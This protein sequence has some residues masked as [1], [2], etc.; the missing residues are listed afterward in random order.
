MLLWLI[1]CLVWL[2]CTLPYAAPS[3]FTEHLTVTPLLNGNMLL[4]FKFS[5]DNLL[6]RRCMY[7]NSSSSRSC[8][9]Q[10]NGAPRD[11]AQ[12]YTQLPAKVGEVYFSSSRGSWRPHEWGAPACHTQGT[13]RACQPRPVP[14]AGLFARVTQRFPPLDAASLP[15]TWALLTNAA[16]AAQSSHRGATK[17]YPLDECRPGPEACTWAVHSAIKLPCIDELTCLTRLVPS[18][19]ELGAALNLHWLV[20]APYYS[21]NV[22][23]NKNMHLKKSAGDLCV[24]HVDPDG[25]SYEDCETSTRTEVIFSFVLTSLVDEPT[26]VRQQVTDV[27]LTRENYS[28][29]IL[30]WLEA[31]WASGYDGDQ[32]TTESEVSSGPWAALR[33]E[34]RGE[35]DTSRPT[36]RRTVEKSPL[37][38]PGSNCGGAGQGTCAGYTLTYSEAP[39]QGQVDMRSE[40]LPPAIDISK[41]VIDSKAIDVYSEVTVRNTH[42]SQSAVLRVV[43]P[44]QLDDD[45]SNA[46]LAVL[47]S[48]S[49]WF[50]PIDNSSIREADVLMENSSACV[51][52]HG[53][54]MDLPSAYLLPA[55]A[56]APP[57][58]TAG[59]PSAVTFLLTL[60]PKC[61]LVLSLEFRKRFLKREFI[62]TDASKGIHVP[63]GAVHW[64]WDG[65]EGVWSTYIAP[66]A[67]VSVPFPDASMPFN[68]I[69]MVSTAFALL[70]GSMMNVL[71]R[72]SS[73]KQP[74]Q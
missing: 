66:A 14:P 25:T 58:G 54:V 5:M 12:L 38:S 57:A 8:V 17:F 70:L 6:K 40:A 44:L 20:N 64:R 69:T 21:V 11:L 45:P 31:A 26:A 63:G 16:C 41:R 56:P 33:Q 29:R 74:A 71:V 23:L 37:P 46:L 24:N 43:E 18:T 62:P 73:L 4:D 42:Q 60:P 9:S 35:L 22:E 47:H 2:L 1:L 52:G 51:A 72:K 65:G 67:L 13:Q 49:Y 30:E 48:Y 19:T 3:L 7:T 53:F 39:A 15:D 55:P 27:P 59:L 36:G 61:K 68:V 50:A 32:A 28:M 34:L 10:S